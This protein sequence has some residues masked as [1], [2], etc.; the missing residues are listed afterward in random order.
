MTTHAIQPSEVARFRNDLLERLG[1]DP[2]AAS[3]LVLS[4]LLEQ[5]RPCGDMRVDSP[6]FKLAEVLNDAG[7][8][9]APT[10]YYWHGWDAM[11]AFPAAELVARTAELWASRPPDDASVFDDTLSWLVLIEHTGHVGVIKF[12]A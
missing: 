1:L 7:I 3:S 5:A 4:R 10:L 9:P 6:R 8:D 12:E 11:D 2:D